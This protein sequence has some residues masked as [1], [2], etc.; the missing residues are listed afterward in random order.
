MRQLQLKIDY[1]DVMDTI[2]APM[3][4][5]LT[6]NPLASVRPVCNEVYGSENPD[7]Q[8]SAEPSPT[9]HT[10]EPGQRDTSPLRLAGGRQTSVASLK[11]VIHQKQ[12]HRQHLVRP[13]RNAESQLV[14]GDLERGV[15]VLGEDGTP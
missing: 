9:R 6:Q 2:W 11:A 3:L 15:D 10:V 5:N 1:D 4:G 13:G 7:C 12:T 14:W 8:L